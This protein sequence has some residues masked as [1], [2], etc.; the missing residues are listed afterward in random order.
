MT[1]SKSTGKKPQKEREMY[2]EN[3]SAP[4]PRKLTSTRNMI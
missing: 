1:V 4:L 2:R 3:G